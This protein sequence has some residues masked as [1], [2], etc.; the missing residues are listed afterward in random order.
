MATPHGHATWTRHMAMPHGHV[1]WPQQANFQLVQ[2]EK[3]E[4][5]A[6]ELHQ[7]NGPTAGGARREE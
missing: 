3:N 2:A 4:Q 1:T 5:V 6:T 7:Q